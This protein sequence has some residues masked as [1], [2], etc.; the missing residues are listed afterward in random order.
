MLLM[1]FSHLFFQVFL[2]VILL[3]DHE[4]GIY[5]SYSNAN[6]LFQLIGNTGILHQN[7]K[8][9]L[10]LTKDVIFMKFS[11]KIC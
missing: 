10:S 4:Y 6:L 11:N 9:M 7:R 8:H 3:A 5:K 1:D 2:I